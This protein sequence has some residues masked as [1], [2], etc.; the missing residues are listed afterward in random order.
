[1]EAIVYLLTAQVFFLR[2]KEGGENYRPQNIFRCRVGREERR[3]SKLRK[4]C[5][6][7]TFKKYLLR[8]RCFVEFFCGDAVFVEFFYGVAVFRTPPPPPPCPPPR[9]LSPLHSLI[10]QRKTMGKVKRIPARATNSLNSLWMES[11]PLIPYQS[12]CPKTSLEQSL[13][14]TTSTWVG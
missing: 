5:K 14:V 9:E 8:W 12:K 3:L 10:L 13:S 4:L 2:K 11:S 6:L 7:H 1:M